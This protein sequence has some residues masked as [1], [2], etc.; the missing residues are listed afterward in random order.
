M[1]LNAT[2]LFSEFL[3]LEKLFFMRRA[4]ILSLYNLIAKNTHAPCSRSQLL[5][6]TGFPFSCLEITETDD[7]VQYEAAVRKDIEVY[8]YGNSMLEEWIEDLKVESG[9]TGLWSDLIVQ[10][11]GSYNPVYTLS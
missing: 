2:D 8:R 3:S 4:A 11:S 9:Y 6:S 1:E 10:E 7:P 5:S